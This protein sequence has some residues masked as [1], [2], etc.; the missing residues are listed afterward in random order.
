MFTEVAN[1]IYRQG[2]IVY[3]ERYAELEHYSLDVPQGG[4]YLIREVR[5]VDDK[6]DIEDIRLLYKEA[7]RYIDATGLDEPEFFYIVE[8]LMRDGKM[9][10]IGET[11]IMGKA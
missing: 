3:L 10:A 11:D 5:L 7:A 9:V 4:K 8:P 2:Q 6:N 1:S